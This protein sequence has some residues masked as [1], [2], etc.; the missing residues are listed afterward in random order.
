MNSKTTRPI[1]SCHRTLGPASMGEH[2]VEW[3]V[4]DLCR[5][6]SCSLWHTDGTGEPGSGK[7]SEAHFQAVNWP[8]ARL[9][10]T[11]KEDQP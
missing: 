8:D 10:A 5:G 7:C 4:A 2:G 6:S 1:P 11:R 9:R 3:P